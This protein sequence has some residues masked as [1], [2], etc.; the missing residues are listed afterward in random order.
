M[1]YLLSVSSVLQLHLFIFYYAL[2]IYLTGHV[3]FLHFDQSVGSI[4]VI[5]LNTFWLFFCH[6]DILF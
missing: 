4:V 2:V 3:K 1:A 5:R 6:L